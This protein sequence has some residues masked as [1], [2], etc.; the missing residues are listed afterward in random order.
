M[1][2][3]I[4]RFEGK[5]IVIEI[6]SKMYNVDNN[7]SKESFKEGDVV[8]VKMEKNVI[9]DIKKNIKE[10]LKRKEYIKN[11]TKDMWN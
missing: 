11:L 6:D 7:I 10:T 8:D 3:I 4:D 1:Q 9:V 2:G 5:Y